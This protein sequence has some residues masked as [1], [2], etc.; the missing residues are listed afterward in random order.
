M[1]NAIQS[2]VQA[3]LEQ[4]SSFAVV[5]RDSEEKIEFSLCPAESERPATVG[6]LS[7]GYPFSLER[8]NGKVQEL[9][10]GSQVFVPVDREAEKALHGLKKHLEYLPKD[11]QNLVW[12]ALRMPS[13]DAR[14]DRLEARILGKTASQE[15]GAVGFGSRLADWFRKPAVGWSALALVLAALLGYGGYQA[16]YFLSAAPAPP[17]PAQAPPNPAIQEAARSIDEIFRV[18]EAKKNDSRAFLRLS[19]VH[20]DDLERASS[21]EIER[22]FTEGPSEELDRLLLVPIKL[23]VLKLDQGADTAFLDEPDN[24]G[25]TTEALARINPEVLAADSVARD[26]LSSLSCKLRSAK[27]EEVPPLPPPGAGGPTK[28]CKDFPLEKAIPGLKAIPTFMNEYAPAPP[29]P[30]GSTDGK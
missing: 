30:A 25:P 5:L 23:E 6:V 22:V 8:L 16:Y 17:A 29:P 13:L 9:P 4:G 3:A 27:P 2:A 28:R 15:Q 24:L 7:P 18:I 19:Q 20:E 26:L 10:R 1:E 21:T 11:M 12:H 14:I